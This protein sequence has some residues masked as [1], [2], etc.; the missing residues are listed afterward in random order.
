[1]P[2]SRR[3]L[4]TVAAIG[5]ALASVA[6]AAIAL[7]PSR[8]AR[9]HAPRGR[10]VAVGAE[11]EYADVI[12]QIGGRYVAVSAIESNP[13]TDPHTFEA[14]AQVASEVSGAELIVQNGVGYDTWMNKIESAAPN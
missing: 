12:S 4:A 5:A 7:A 13:N 9:L 3:L 8:G 14:S 2:S 10:I 11:R 1:M 6:T